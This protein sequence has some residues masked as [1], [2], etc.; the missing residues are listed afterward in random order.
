[1]HSSP[2]DSQLIKQTN[3]CRVKAHVSFFQKS[4]TTNS[5]KNMQQKVRS[6]WSFTEMIQ[7]F[8]TL[9]IKIES[10]NVKGKAEKIKGRGEN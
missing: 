5:S 6:R 8:G 2:F 4:F 7:W 3:Y 1:M 9:E 10:G